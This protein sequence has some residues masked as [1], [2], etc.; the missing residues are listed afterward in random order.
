M[1]KVL[2]ALFALAVVGF[3]VF[4]CQKTLD[5]MKSDD[6]SIAKLVPAEC[7]GPYNVTLVNELA[8]SGGWQWTWKVNNPNPGNGDNGTVQKLSHI[9]ILLSSVT[10]LLPED[11]LAASWSYDGINWYNVSTIPVVDPSLNGCPTLVEPSIKFDLG[12]NG[13]IRLVITKNMEAGGIMYGY[14]KS[15]NTTGCGSF[16]F[17]GISCVEP[18]NE[19][20]SMSQGF[21]F[22]KPLSEVNA[23]PGGGILM[24]GK[25]YTAVE[26]RSLWGISGNIELKRAFTQAA[27]IKLSIAAGLMTSGGP[28][29]MYVTNIENVLN[30]L[31]KLTPANLVSVNKGLSATTRKN[32]G[33]WAGSIGSWIDLNHCETNSPN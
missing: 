4:S 23:W 12:G 19:A 26:A 7:A 29:D 10:C 22:A 18:P 9:N 21:W 27:T 14:Y 13:Y 31:P 28:A 16:C 1:K 17:E 25:Y 5:P 24:G 6:G 8:I 20:C 30:M 32:L 11:V 3:G 2:I 33:I 15:G